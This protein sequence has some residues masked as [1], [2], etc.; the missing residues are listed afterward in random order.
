[1]TVPE[2]RSLI[3]SCLERGASDLVVD[4]ADVVFIG[5]QGLSLLLDAHKRLR[6]RGGALSVCGASPFV[7]RLM[8]TA[9]LEELLAR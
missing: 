1:M 5:A 8:K 9:G 4:L 2:L 3:G 7:A 6:P